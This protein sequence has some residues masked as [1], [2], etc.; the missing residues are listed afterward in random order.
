MLNKVMKDYLFF[1]GINKYLTQHEY[2]NAEQSQ[3][4][5]ALNEVKLCYF[6]I[7]LN[8]HTGFIHISY[9]ELAKIV[10][11]YQNISITLSNSVSFNV[12][13]FKI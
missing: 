2:S 12:L 9:Y 3:L 4:Y 6:Y 8:T 11:H 10:F 13:K 5:D 1:E 7:E